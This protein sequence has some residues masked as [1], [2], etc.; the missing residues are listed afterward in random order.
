MALAIAAF[1]LI[2]LV[3]NFSQL[4]ESQIAI[5]GVL[6]LAP[7]IGGIVYLLVL[8]IVL[9]S[10]IILFRINEQLSEINRVLHAD[11]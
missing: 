5:R 8:R 6:A 10:L 2:D 9:E 3:T 1:D 4:N 7:L 11:R